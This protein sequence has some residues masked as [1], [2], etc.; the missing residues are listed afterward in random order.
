MRAPGIEFDR[1]LLQRYGGRGPRY[2][3]Y[4][5]A[6]QFHEDFKEADYRR[7]VKQS[8]E[9]PIP[10]PLSLYIHIPFCESLCYYCGCTKIVTRHP[11]QAAAYLE[12]LF[13]E[14]AL[15]GS[16]FD[17]DR[18]VHQ[19]HL[20]GGTPNFLDSGQLR[21]LMESLRA[22][23]SMGAGANEEYSIEVDPRAATKD[24]IFELAALGFNRISFGVQDFDPKVQEAVNRIQP[25]EM[26]ERVVRWAR[27]A[28]F[29]S[30]SIDLIYGLPFQNLDSFDS[31]LEQTLAIRPDRLAVYSYAH[32]P[33]MFKA[34][35]LIK[36]ET[37]PSP[38]EKLALL[39]L[40]IEKLPEAGYRYIGMDHFALA[41]DEL[42]VAQDEGHLQR[43]F[44]GYSTHA[45]CDL[46]GLGISAI[47]NISECYSQNEKRT[48]TY[49]ALLDE[50]V[51]PVVRG[52]ELSAD[53]KLRRDVIQG[54]MCDG[55]VEYGTLERKYA[56]SFEEYFD[57]ELK[58]LDM[59]EEDGL[60]TVGA[61]D[62]EVS[63]SGW[64]LVR[65]VAS[66]FDAY[67]SPSSKQ[68]FSSFV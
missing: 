22:N 53:D 21:N 36:A 30:V 35:R 12:K 47:G 62:I 60:V 39:E 67:L 58:L 45:Y 63:P 15:Q 42:V 66:V 3:S 11:E 61:E 9:Y 24:S 57:E 29:V 6:S 64:L 44:Q 10:A 17:A 68:R 13:L 33:E 59:L 46:V 49:G 27:D 50:G 48:K 55:V 54:L 41:D 40:T 25:V 28:G 37:L 26:T 43:N 2:T 51:L 52:I 32:L 7:Q 19:L 31:T 18:T 14:I 23:F 56:I 16:L 1:D 20:G 65:A 38:D 8:N 34:Q 4:P 5:P